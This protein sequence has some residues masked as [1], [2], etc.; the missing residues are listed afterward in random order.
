MVAPT[1][2]LGPA[3]HDPGA[4]DKLW[5]Y[6]T[7]VAWSEVSVKDERS[8][9]LSAKYGPEQPAI[10]TN[11]LS[12]LAFW[13]SVLGLLI[14]LF[15]YGYFG[16]SWLLPIGAMVSVIAML[17]GLNVTSQIRRRRGTDLGRGFARAG[18][19]IAL[20]SLIWIAVIVVIEANAAAVF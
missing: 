14:S 12:I 16:G 3:S 20:V 7:D 10:R 8:A 17:L 11:P 15:P 18:I 1:W 6:A 4:P 2:L 19:I 9:R 5:E 13:C